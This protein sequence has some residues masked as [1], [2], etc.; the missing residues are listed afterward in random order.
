MSGDG[1]RAAV[2]S[3][4]DGERLGGRAMRLDGRRVGVR[5]ACD[6]GRHS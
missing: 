3:A 4:S 6:G 5:S 1:R 2:R